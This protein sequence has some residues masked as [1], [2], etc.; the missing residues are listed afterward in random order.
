MSLIGG[1]PPPKGECPSC[2][3]P[4]RGN[5]LCSSCSRTRPLFAGVEPGHA[6]RKKVEQLGLFGGKR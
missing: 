1:Q 6:G 4:Q 5:T 2:H 3:K